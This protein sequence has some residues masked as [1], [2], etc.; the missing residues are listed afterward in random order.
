MLCSSKS[1][2]KIRSKLNNPAWFQPPERCP[3][4]AGTMF[5]GGKGEKFTKDFVKSDFLKYQNLSIF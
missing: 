1:S 2:D 4:L 3:P 5:A